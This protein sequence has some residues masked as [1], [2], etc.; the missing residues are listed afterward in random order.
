MNVSPQNVNNIMLKLKIC[1][2]EYYD[3]VFTNPYFLKADRQKELVHYAKYLSS[4]NT[5]VSFP[6]STDAGG[7]SKIVNLKNMKDDTVSNRDLLKILP[8]MLNYNRN[9]VIN[10]FY[11]DFG[12]EITPKEFCSLLRIFTYHTKNSTLR[13]PGVERTEEDLM[14]KVYIDRD[15]LGYFVSDGLNHIHYIPGTS[16]LNNKMVICAPLSVSTSGF[17]F[18]E[19][20]KVSIISLPDDISGLGRFLLKSYFGCV[21]QQIPDEIKLFSYVPTLCKIDPFME[22]LSE[23]VLL[24][25][26][27]SLPSIKLLPIMK[28]NKYNSLS[29]HF[30][31]LLT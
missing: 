3:T 21:N 18:K 13:R 1:H 5:I 10:G 17:I 2:K 7:M 15:E 4:I 20:R 25:N 28:S 19:E 9:I 22:L 14:D 11:L 31:G 27:V 8:I 24:L 6:L 16:I 26:S 12:F 30:P 29:V 23:L